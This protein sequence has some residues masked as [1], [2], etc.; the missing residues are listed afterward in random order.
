MA[1][2]GGLTEADP[3]EEID[4]TPEMAACADVH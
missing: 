3:L 4:V 1:G 2:A